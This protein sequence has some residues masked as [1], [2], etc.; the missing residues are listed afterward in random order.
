MPSHQ[1][2]AH[3]ASLPPEAETRFASLIVFACQEV[4]ALTDQFGGID[5]FVAWEKQLYDQYI[6]PV[7]V[8]WVPNVMEPAVID[9]PAKM[10]LE[11]LTRRAYAKGVPLLPPTVV[12]PQGSA[13]P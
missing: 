13:A 7:D 9:M 2:E 8:P 1:F 11:S 10:L 5:A 3:L 12:V 6:A 4:H